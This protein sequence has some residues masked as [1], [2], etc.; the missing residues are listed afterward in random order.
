MKVSKGRGIQFFKQPFFQDQKKYT[1][2]MLGAGRKSIMNVF[3][4]IG[5]TFGKKKKGGK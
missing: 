2:N 5:K 4:N 3:E 1:A